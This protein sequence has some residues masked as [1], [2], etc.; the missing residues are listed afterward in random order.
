APHY[1]EE[2]S[3]RAGHIPTAHS[4]PWSRAAQEA[5]RFKS[6]AELQEIYLNE[7]E[8][9]REHPVIAYCR[10]G[11]RP[12]HTWFVLRYLLGFENVRNYDGSWTEWG[13][14]VGVPIELSDPEAA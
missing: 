4:V 14:A 13:S 7:L 3:L 9:D 5:G 6:R 1:P 10:I 2:G 12:A 11:E 8:L